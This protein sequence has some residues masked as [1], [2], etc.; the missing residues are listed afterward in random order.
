MSTAHHPAPEVE[1]MRFTVRSMT[2][3]D[4]DDVLRLW[5]GTIGMGLSEADARES[6]ERYLERNPGFS[7]VAHDDGKLVGAALCGHDGRRGFIHHLA[8][9]EDHWQ[10]GV[11]RRLSA[12]CLSSLQKAG[13]DKCHIFVYADNHQARAFWETIGWTERTELIIMSKYT[14]DSV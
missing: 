5:Q 4:Y 7:L 8:V 11:G 14:S 6:I 13:I 2:L 3:E 1:G 10:Q 12:E 9:A